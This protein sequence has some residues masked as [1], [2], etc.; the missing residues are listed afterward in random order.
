[1]SLN[2]CTFVQLLK[3]EGT[4]KVVFIYL[5]ICL[6]KNRKTFW[7]MATPP[8]RFSFQI[9]LS[10]VQCHQRLPLQS[11]LLFDIQAFQQILP[12]S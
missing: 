11:Q 12:N 8:P 10:G 1:M 6:L 3:A 9:R 4:G 5:F 2:G 7:S